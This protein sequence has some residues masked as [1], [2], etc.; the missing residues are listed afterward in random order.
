MVDLIN[1]AGPDNVYYCDTDSLFVNIRGYNALKGYRMVGS[2]LGKL[3]LE[4]SEME[5]TFYRP[6]FYSFGDDNKC[7]GL[8]KKST[9]IY[10]DDK[11]IIAEMQAWKRFKGALRDGKTSSQEISIITKEFSKV[12]D[13]GIVQP[14]G[15]VKPYRLS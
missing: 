7:K 4:G 5:A 9:I 14:D 13:K 10:E 11:K 2:E 12:Y 6:K 3:K 1:I 15:S 8:K